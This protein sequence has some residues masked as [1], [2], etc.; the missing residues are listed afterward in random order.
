MIGKAGLDHLYRNSPTK[1]EGI[2]QTVAT[3]HHLHF[4]AKQERTSITET[5]VYSTFLRI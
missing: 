3:S 1:T 4:P 2:K 5:Q